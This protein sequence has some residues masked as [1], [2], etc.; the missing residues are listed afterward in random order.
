M[1]SVW[2]TTL[3]IEIACSG[4]FEWYY[5][6][7]NED[8]DNIITALENNDR[9]CRLSL[10][11]VSSS[12]LEKIAAVIQGPFPALTQLSL[13]TNEDELVSFPE[14]FLSGPA[15]RLQ[16]LRLEGIAFPGKWLLLSTAHR[17]VGLHLH[18]I[19]HS[20]YV[21]PEAMVTHLSAMPNLKQLSI[22]FQSS[23]SRPDWRDPSNR[24]P[25]L[26][27]HVV[28]PALTSFSFFYGASGYVEDF[29]ARID[30]PL[31]NYVYIRFIFDQF[32]PV[33]DS[34][35]NTPRLHYF[36]SRAEHLRA[37]NRATLR[38]WRS[39]VNFERNSMSLMLSIFCTGWDQQLSAV[40]QL[41]NSSLPPFSDVETLQIRE[42]GFDGPHWRYDI[43]G[44]QWLELIHPFSAV[45]NLYLSKKVA[46][47]FAFALQELTG[48]R[49]TE[50]LPAL[51]NIFV[52][53]SRLRLSRPAQEAIMQFVIA[54]WLSGY[55]VAVHGWDGRW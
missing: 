36:L 38:F 17:L 10:G 47:R 21:S 15:P 27:T 22:G 3:P 31:L 55:P 45:K 23:W 49:V 24:P 39:V 20:N 32:V 50:A 8:T 12:R 40:T 5:L 16:I 28:L 29:V 18:N 46:P 43:E 51:Q 35:F 54:R 11:N 33:F 7:R 26:L 19:P 6:L 37:H 52:E 41:C 4:W 44:S 14:E 9:I 1:L 34:A 48:E 2:P 42:E 25:C 13:C 30:V 53:G